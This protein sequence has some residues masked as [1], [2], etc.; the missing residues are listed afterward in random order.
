MTNASQQDFDLLNNRGG[1][2][3]F[4]FGGGVLVSCST[5]TPIYH[6]VFFCCRIPVVLENCRSSRGEG[7][8]AV[9][10]PCTL[11]PDPPLN[12]HNV[13]YFS[14]DNVMKIFWW[15]FGSKPG[16]FTESLVD[17]WAVVSFFGISLGSLGSKPSLFADS[18][19]DGWAVIFFFG[20]SSRT[21]P[22]YWV[23][24]RPR[25]CCSFLLWFYIKVFRLHA[26]SPL[27]SHF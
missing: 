3:I 17:G 10:T 5:L 22:L 23:S 14:G 16:L 4:F 1:S 12:H 18:L 2:R 26:R 21:R 20:V 25:V 6:I 11:P 15:Y 13:R 7:G 27:L 8:G 9:R 19:V 24:C